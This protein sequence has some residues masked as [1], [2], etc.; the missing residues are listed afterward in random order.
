MK[1]NEIISTEEASKILYVTPY[2]IR[3]YIKKGLLK[4]KKIGKRYLIAK[5]EVDKLL[6]DLL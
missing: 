3:E 5:S 6:S 2:T 4:A 1:V